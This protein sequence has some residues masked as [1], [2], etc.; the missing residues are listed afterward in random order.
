MTT[1]SRNPVL[2]TALRGLALGRIVLG[3]GSL[4]APDTLARALGVR[5]TPELRYMTRIFGA[6]AMALGLGYLTA[7]AG[8]RR[9]WQR[10][11]LMVDVTDTVQ[12]A[13]HLARRDLPGPAAVALVALTGGYMTVGAARLLLPEDGEEPR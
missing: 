2:A 9:R 13:A 5:P 3:A 6:R 8:E 11:A 10:L 12:G 1:A 7:P 4:A